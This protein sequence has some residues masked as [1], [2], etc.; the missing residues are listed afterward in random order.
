MVIAALD[1]SVKDAKIQVASMHSVIASYWNNSLP[2]ALAAL[3]L[4]PSEFDSYLLNE[5]H[6]STKIHDVYNPDG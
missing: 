3:S 5:A 4:S 6:V 2:K 1:I